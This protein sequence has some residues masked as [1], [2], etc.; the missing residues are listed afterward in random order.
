MRV[1]VTGAG[2]LLGRRV[3]DEARSREHEVVGLGRADLDVTDAARAR[4]LLEREKP[5]AVIHCAAYTAVD[6]AE[7]EPRL[8][9]AVN[10]DGTRNV[11][12]ATVGCGALF[13]YMSTDY[14]FDGRKR[15]PYLPT[16]EP[17]PLSVYGRTKL[18]GE[19]VTRKA[20][21]NALVVRTSWLYGSD[22][23]FV[24]TILARARRGELLRVVDDQRGRPTWAP[25]AARAIF[26]LL[27][28]GA[29]GIWHVAD[30]GEC[31][32]AD[33]AREAVRVAGLDAEV[34]AISTTE[35]GA[36]APRPAYS[37]LDLAATE[38]RLGRRTP[39]WREGLRSMLYG[40]ATTPRR[41][42]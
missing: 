35:Y 26:D 6:R 36:P 3:V 13:V 40:R 22:G 11:V 41:E 17:A 30:G 39:D 20:A 9:R 19:E 4:S 18:E 37:V 16:D 12:E 38:N 33:L 24:P 29:S 25:H 1:V 21:P 27:A 34:Q 31:T 23:G 32:W 2:G 10:R 42:S 8:A 5:T 14:V 15:A 28:S 7:A